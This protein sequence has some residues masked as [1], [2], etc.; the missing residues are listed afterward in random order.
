MP[1]LTTKAKVKDWLNIKGAE[2]DDIISDM[3]S[4]YSEQVSQYTGRNLIA[5]DHTEVRDGHGGAKM[6]TDEFPINSV[7]SVKVD[8][9]VVPSNAFTFTKN[10]IILLHQGFNRGHGN[11][12][13]QYNAGYATVPA[14]IGQAIVE[15]IELRFK[16]RGSNDLASKGLAGETTTYVLD[17]MPKFAQLVLNGY[18]QLGI[19]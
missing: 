16:R 11:V 9:V 19:R 2:Y 3:I 18:K 7:A 10:S 17:P 6:S 4:A 8:G 5:M 13:L 1:D 12:V 14:D 15:W